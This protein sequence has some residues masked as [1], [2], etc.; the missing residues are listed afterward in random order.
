M[1]RQQEEIKTCGSAAILR[2]S[3]GQDLSMR[4]A[5]GQQDVR[6]TS[7]LTFGQPSPIMEVKIQCPC[8]TRYKFDVEPIDG[9]LPGP[10]NCPTCGVDGT[11]AGNAIVEQVLSTQVT[12]P[13]TAAVSPKASEK[14]RIRLS[15]PAVREPAPEVAAPEAAEVPA[16]PSG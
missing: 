4:N 9:R 10:V 13:G 8:G 5:I 7:F 16:R 1:A 6:G 2:L 11:A 15:L 14:P 3:F 12:M